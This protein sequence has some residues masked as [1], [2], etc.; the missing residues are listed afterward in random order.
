LSKLS[1]YYKD[2]TNKLLVPVLLIVYKSENIT[3]KKLTHYKE[4]LLSYSKEIEHLDRIKIEFI[5]EIDIDKYDV[6]RILKR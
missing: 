1:D 4:R 3:G 5:N 2:T 6:K